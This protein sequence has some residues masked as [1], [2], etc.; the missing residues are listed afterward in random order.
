MFIVFLWARH[1]A[2]TFSA[3]PPGEAEIYKNNIISTKIATL[4]MSKIHEEKM[5]MSQET[6]PEIDFSQWTN[7]RRFFQGLGH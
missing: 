3:S 2:Y 7:S 6:I 5:T 1:K 4:S